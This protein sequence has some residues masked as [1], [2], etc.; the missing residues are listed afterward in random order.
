VHFSGIVGKGRRTLEEGERVDYEIIQGEK[1]PQA[2]DVQRA[3]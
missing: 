3:A 2:V 1:G